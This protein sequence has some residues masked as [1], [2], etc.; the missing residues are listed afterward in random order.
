MSIWHDNFCSF[1]KYLPIHWSNSFSCVFHTVFV[2]TTRKP[3]LSILVIV[4]VVVL[5]LV[6]AVRN[7]GE[8]YPASTPFF[9]VVQGQLHKN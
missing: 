4:V 5:V 3:S 1:G 6:V 9:K 7:K 8:N 2:R